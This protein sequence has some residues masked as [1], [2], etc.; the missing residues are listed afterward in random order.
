[1]PAAQRQRAEVARATVHKDVAD[2]GGMPQ[3]LS[4]WSPTVASVLPTHVRVEEFMGLAAAALRRSAELR[5]AAEANPHSLMIALRECAALGHV[6]IRGTYALVPYKRNRDKV[7]EGVEVVGVEEVGGV[8][9]RMYRGGTVKAVHA[10]VVRAN[11]LFDVPDEMSLPVHQYNR[12]EGRAARGPLIG[13]YAWA[14]LGGSVL[15]DVVIMGAEEVAKHRAS[16]RSGDAFWGPADGEGPWTQDMWKKTALHKLEKVVPTT[17]EWR[18]AVVHTEAVAATPPQEGLPDRPAA[19][20][21][22]IDAQEDDGEGWPA[23]AQ[24][25]DGGG[26]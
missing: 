18:Q 12:L 26:K 15:S 1:M 13:V 25:G 11:D 6:P 10:R 4:Y 3:F 21:D 23:A 20:P 14:K 7:P 19:Q 2:R 17:R 22:Y 9:E 5:Q 16:S 8:I 24:P